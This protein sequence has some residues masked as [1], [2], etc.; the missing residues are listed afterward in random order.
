MVWREDA[1]TSSRQ[2]CQN[3]ESVRV[4]RRSP[5]LRHATHVTHATHAAHKIPFLPAGL[6]RRFKVPDKIGV[7][8]EQRGR[9]GVVKM[10]MMFMKSKST[11][12]ASLCIS[13]G[14]CPPA[15]RAAIVSE[16]GR[17]GSPFRRHIV[18]PGRLHTNLHTLTRGMSSQFHTANSK[19]IVPTLR[20][21]RG[22]R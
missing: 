9:L 4:H 14:A 15:E 12:S 17:S 13:A 11:T 7:A 19:I 20:H 2:G 3:T 8:A 18:R 5:S 6:K 22:R 1:D 16:R 21:Q 10:I